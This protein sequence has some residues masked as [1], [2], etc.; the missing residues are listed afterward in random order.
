MIGSCKGVPGHNDMRRRP[1]AHRRNIG[2]WQRV[3]VIS[4]PLEIT[5]SRE[6]TAHLVDRFCGR[7]ELRL[8]RKNLV[9]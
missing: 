4:P 7:L 1:G 9:H 8:P 6:V 2:G 3:L 5:T